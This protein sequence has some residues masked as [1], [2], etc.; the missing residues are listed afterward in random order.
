MQISNNFRINYNSCN[1]TLRVIVMPTF[2]HDCHQPWLHVELLKM[3]ATG[4]LNFD[5]SRH[6]I[7]SSGT[8]EYCLLL[9][10]ITKL[11]TAF[12]DF[13]APYASSSKE[14]DQCIRP[15]DQTLPTIVAESGWSES[16]PRL[17]E[18]VRLWLKGG[19]GNVQLAILFK[20]SKVR[21]NMVKGF[22]QA[23][24]IGEDGN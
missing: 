23:Y 15:F 10:Y 16:H 12:S 9:S 2:V 8:S 3:F 1:R 18:D 4:F 24:N 20:W 5:E 13:E 7:L 14:P 11:G 21:D 19:A 17:V 6:L 22:L